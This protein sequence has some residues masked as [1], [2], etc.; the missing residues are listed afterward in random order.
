MNNDVR[1]SCMSL[2]IIKKFFVQLACPHKSTDIQYWI[3]AI[4]GF[5]GESQKEVRLW[6]WYVHKCRNCEKILTIKV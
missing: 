5:P 2:K 4:K 6:T 1:F 3:E